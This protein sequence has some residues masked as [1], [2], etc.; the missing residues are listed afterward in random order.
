MSKILERRALRIVQSGDFPLYLFALAAEEIDLVSD[1]ARISRD[2]AGKLLGYQRPEKRS[3]VKQI[4]EYLDSG[5]VLFPN[6]LIMALPETVRFRSSRGPHPGD[7]LATSG[8]L[9]IPLPSSPSDPRP[10]WIVDGQQR[11]LA[12]SRTTN[13]RLAIPV[14]GFVAANLEVQ[15]EQFL[16]VNTVSPLPPNLVTELLPEVAGA[17]S[18]RLAARKLPSALVDMLAQDPESPFSGLV[19]RASSDAGQRKAQVVTDNSLV[20]AVKESLESPSG[21][22]FPYRN[23]AVGTT[24]TTGIRTVLISY[25]AAVKETFPEAWGLPATRSRLMHGAGIRSMARLMERVIPHVDVD[26]DQAVEHIAAEL[27]RIA[28]ICRWTDGVWEELSLPW[29]EVQN[30]PR[31]ISALSNFLARKYLDARA[32]RR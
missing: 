29:N 20:E 26:S 24:D 4:Q 7:G 12:L 8:T 23:M 25:W 19:R 6:A 10:A 28:P 1:V 13:R 27:R 5:D 32:H 2:E 3:H 30:T 16:R 17:P 11:S 21:V 9:E 22:L 15:R 31:H 14:A 18:P